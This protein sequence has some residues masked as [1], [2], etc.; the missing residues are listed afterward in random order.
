MESFGIALA[1]L[2]GLVAAPVFCFALVKLVRPFRWIAALGFWV[3]VATVA[4]F[5]TE[6]ALVSVWGI[7][8]TR[9]HLG[10]AFFPVHALLT[11]GLAPACACALLLGTRSLA[12][13]W[14]LVAAFCWFAGAAAIFYQYDV[15]ETLYGI[16][17]I[18]GPYQWPH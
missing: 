10:A 15:A 3:G 8:G 12:R 7:L 13:W 17:G 6:L 14:P 5:G 2:G 1:L 4:L 11:L 18:G 16:D 9:R